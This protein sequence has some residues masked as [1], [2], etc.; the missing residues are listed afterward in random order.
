MKKLI[1]IPLLCWLNLAYADINSQQVVNTFASDLNNIKIQLQNGS[2]TPAQASVL[3][4]VI[5]ARQNNVII[6]QNQ[7]IVNLLNKPTPSK[8]AS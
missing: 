1:I 4:Q 6:Q 5:Q 8:A 3:L 7:E 2:M